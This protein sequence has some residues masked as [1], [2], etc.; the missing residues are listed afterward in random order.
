MCLERK[1][2]AKMYVNEVFVIH[3][4]GLFVVRINLKKDV[5]TDET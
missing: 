5:L 3:F 4:T 2:F 1:I